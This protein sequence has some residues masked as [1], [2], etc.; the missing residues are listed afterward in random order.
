M[1][2]ATDTDEGETMETD[3]DSAQH[4]TGKGEMAK[5]ATYKLIHFPDLDRYVGLAWNYD[6]A[7]L[8]GTRDHATYTEA[9]A[10][11]QETC[12]SLSIELK[13]F[14]GEHRYDSA[15]GQIINA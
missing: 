8:I 4:G 6:Q 5:Q 12:D 14:D 3:T 7:V 2:N 10:E 13:W 9:K 15:S 11:L 1:N